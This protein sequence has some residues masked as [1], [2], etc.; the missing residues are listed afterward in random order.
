[1]T[2]ECI[3]LPLAARIENRVSIFAQNPR[4]AVAKVAKTKVLELKWVIWM[5]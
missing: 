5:L 1:L 4:F 3:S 2:V